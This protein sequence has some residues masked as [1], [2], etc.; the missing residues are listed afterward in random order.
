MTI[1]KLKGSTHRATQQ[2]QVDWWTRMLSSTDIQSCA[3]MRFLSSPVEHADQSDKHNV[4]STSQL[5]ESKNN[6]SSSVKRDACAAGLP[7][8]DE[9]GGKFQ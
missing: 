7:D 8:E 1:L 3:S 9:Q 6:M 2:Q 5:E 4:K